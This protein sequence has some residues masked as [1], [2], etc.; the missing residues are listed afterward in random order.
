[1]EIIHLIGILPLIKLVVFAICALYACIRGGEIQFS[2]NCK[3][4]VLP[5]NKTKKKGK[6][7]R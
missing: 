2:K 4:T 3:I 5:G 6:A 7:V 1:M